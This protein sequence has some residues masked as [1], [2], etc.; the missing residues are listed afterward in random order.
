MVNNTHVKTKIISLSLHFYGLCYEIELFY[1][2][3][4]QNPQKTHFP[5][6]DAI[7]LFKGT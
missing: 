4:Y 1:D 7:D 5:L 3:K 6:I 2:R